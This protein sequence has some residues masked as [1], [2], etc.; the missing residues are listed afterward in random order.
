MRE[1][2]LRYQKK[3]FLKSKKSSSQFQLELE[4]ICKRTAYLK[5]G[6]ASV[7]AHLPARDDRLYSEYQSVL[8]QNC[9]REGRGEKPFCPGEV[10][11]LFVRT[12]LERYGSAE[13]P[14]TPAELLEAF[15]ECKSYFMVMAW[16]H[17]LV[18]LPSEDQ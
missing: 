3:L 18:A 2:G 17:R 5:Y 7:I 15:E 6:W 11:K 8:R 4:S 16:L 9:L 13:Q 10:Q 14:L 1:V 12:F